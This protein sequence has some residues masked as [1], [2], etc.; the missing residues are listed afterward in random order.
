MGRK[1]GQHLSYNDRLIIERMLLLKKYSIQDIADAIG[2][3]KRTIYYEIKRSTYIHTNTDLTTEVRY[4]PDGSQ[5]RYRRLLKMKGQKPL[6]REDSEFKTYVEYMIT[7]HK[8]SPEAALHKI[9]TDELALDLHITSVQTIYSGIRKGYFE[10]ISLAELPRHGKNK[11]KKKKVSVQKR[12]V[13]G[14]SIERRPD[15]V[16]ART[17]FG[18]WE[19][20]CLCGKST[21]RKT[22]LVLTERKTRMEIVEVLKKHTAAEVVKAL[23]R[24]EK[25]F[26]C[27]FYKVFKTITVDNGAEFMDFIGMEKA[28]YRVGQRTKVYYCHPH[29]PHERGT[30]ENNNILLRRPLPKGSNF[31]KDLNRTKAKYAEEWINLYPRGIFKGRCSMDLYEEELARLG[32][33]FAI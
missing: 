7:K 9:K 27:D 33:R 12:L 17:T 1:K 8:Y 18:H 3:C 4:N 21:N 32:C 30:N 29:A 5:E 15:E 26:G 6:L 31:D 24:I 28:L 22:A 20:D 16:D 25:R 19:M 2:C 14:T 10:N 13:K 23:N 11:R